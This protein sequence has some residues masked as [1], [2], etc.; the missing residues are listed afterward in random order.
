MSDSLK[1]VSLLSAIKEA[2]SKS[3]DYPYWF[4]WMMGGVPSVH[5]AQNISDY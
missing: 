2:I 5:S 4:P 1:S 3:S